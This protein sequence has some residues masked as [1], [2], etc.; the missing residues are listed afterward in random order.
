MI[1][2]VGSELGLRSQSTLDQSLTSSIPICVMLQLGKQ[3]INLTF[4]GSFS[5]PNKY[6]DHN[7]TYFIKL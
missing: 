2:H 6:D 3:A 5:S 4:C 1:W 7:Y